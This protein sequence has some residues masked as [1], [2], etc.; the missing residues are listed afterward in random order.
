MLMPDMLCGP[1]HTIRY[2]AEG[3]A[4]AATARSF[5]EHA[6]VTDA[7]SRSAVPEGSDRIGEYRLLE[8][9]TGRVRTS[10]RPDR[11][12]VNSGPN[13]PYDTAMRYP[14]FRTVRMCRGSAAFSS[15]LR[16]SSATC[17]STAFETW[18]Y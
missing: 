5:R 9:G 1:A 10:I 16:R 13:S 3:A 14:L 12:D 4:A 11:S 8:S 18:G 6:T 15:S 17:V 2:F 7:H